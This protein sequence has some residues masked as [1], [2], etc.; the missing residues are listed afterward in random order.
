MSRSVEEWIGKTPDS[1]IPPRVQ[2]RVFQKH[3]GVC[4]K[5][6][7]KLEP[8]KWACDHI[9]ALINGGEHRER[10]LQPLCVS[11][12]HSWKTREDV[13]EKSRNYKR[14]ASHAGIKARKSRPLPGSKASGIR[15]RMDGRVERRPD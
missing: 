3:G 10:N 13:A 7:R 2:L 1:A 15:K 9:I 6:T 5:C 14:A 12:C 8:G 4:P 11:P